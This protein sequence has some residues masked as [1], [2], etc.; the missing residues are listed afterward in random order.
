M[1]QRIRQPGGAPE[2]LAAAVPAS[3]VLP[4]ADAAE[5]NGARQ[6]PAA[7]KRRL[8]APAGTPVHAEV[9]AAERPAAHFPYPAGRG[10]SVRPTWARCSG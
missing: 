8:A 1:L 10:R 6:T 5:G 3:N 2:N 7:G 9:L 4:V